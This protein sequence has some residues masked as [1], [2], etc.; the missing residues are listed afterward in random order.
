MD[1]SALRRLQAAPLRKLGKGRTWAAGRGLHV[2]VPMYSNA[3][4]NTEHRVHFGTEAQSGT[5]A[6][7][8]EVLSMETSENGLS[9]RALVGFYMCDWALCGGSGVEHGSII[10]AG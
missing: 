10:I 4:Q 6:L 9:R 2:H 5:D 8:S 1:T 3:L 7:Y